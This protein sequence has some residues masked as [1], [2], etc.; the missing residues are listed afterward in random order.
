MT[1]QKA[2]RTVYFS[3][4]H[5]IV[6]KVSFLKRLN[7][8]P[9]FLKT[10]HLIACQAKMAKVIRHKQSI[11]LRIASQIYLSRQ[12]LL[13]I[14]MIIKLLMIRNRVLTVTKIW[15]LMELLIMG[16]KL[17]MELRRHNATE[18]SCKWTSKMECS[19]LVT[20][21]C[22]SSTQCSIETTIV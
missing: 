3:L 21:S 19:L 5:Q 2:K 7:I 4:K 6:K 22:V 13:K 20:A 12:K 16:R 9:N 15:T 11:S 17:K 18:L 8:N 1:Y 10:S 14:K